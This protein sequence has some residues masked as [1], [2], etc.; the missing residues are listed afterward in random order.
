[1]PLSLLVL[2]LFVF[3]IDYYSFT[4]CYKKSV[5]F[6]MLSRAQIGDCCDVPSLRGDS[7]WT[8]L[9][10]GVRSFG[11]KTICFLV[12][13]KRSLDFYESFEEPAEYVEYDLNIGIVIWCGTF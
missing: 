9:K 12:Y 13:F 10:G 3:Y 4:N 8:D 2:L 6:F 5:V 1:M 7:W 11:E